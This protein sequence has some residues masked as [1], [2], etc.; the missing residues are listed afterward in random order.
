MV[1]TISWASKIFLI[2]A[3]LLILLAFLMVNFLDKSQNTPISGLFI[4]LM[5]MPSYYALY[6]WMGLGK[7]VS[8]LFI[9]S[10]YAF[11]IE[12]F[13]ISTG[14]PYSS[15]HYTD[16]IG[17]KIAGYTPYTLP[18]AYVP[19]F[20][21]SIYLASTIS[22]NIYKYFIITTLLVLLVDLMLDP[23]AVALK[24]W[25]YHSPGIFYSIPLMNFLGWILTGFLAVLITYPLLRKDL[26]Q[27]KPSGLVSSL[28]LILSF[29]M[30]VCFYLGLIVP[31]LIGL[32]LLLFVLWITRFEVAIFYKSEN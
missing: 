27:S 9:L 4:I 13:A 6:R 10:L 12:T 1:L 30:A 32:F 25:V 3:I 7:A 24:F 31:G 22:R 19:I 11:T 23:A 18:F 8:I 26:F 28:F 15:F 29:W 20:I 14:F 21:G 17:Y 2:L 16:Q 5:A